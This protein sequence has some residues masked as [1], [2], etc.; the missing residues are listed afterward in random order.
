MTR[1]GLSYRFSEAIV[2]RPSKSVVRGLR[3]TDRGDPD[4]ARFESEHSDYIHALQRVGLK[5]T[6]LPALE[7][8]PDSVFIEDA[9]LCLPGVVILLRPGAPSRT[10]EPAIL[11]REL[12]ALGHEVICCDSSGFIDGGDILVTDSEVLVGLSGR[13]DRA[14]FDWL[15]SVLSRRGYV[16]QAAR[17]PAGVLHFKSECCLLDSSTILATKRLSGAE[18]FAGFEVLT[19][20]GGEEAAANSIRVNDTVLVPAGFPATAQLLS[21]AAYPV[22]R[23]PVTQAGLLDGGLSCMSLRLGNLDE[24]RDAAREGSTSPG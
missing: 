2:R 12:R 8:F 21:N 1:H 5:V 19:V 24:R 9:A 10:G 23:V 13:T 6:V 15:H 17:T 22:E 14:G 7:P 20:P 3:T 4:F 11:A 16:V 18:C